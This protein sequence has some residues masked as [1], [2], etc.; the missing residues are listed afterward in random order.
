MEYLL[1]GV[2]AAGLVGAGALIWF[3]VKRWGKNEDRAEAKDSERDRLA[4]RVAELTRI[5]ADYAE[6]VDH[7]RAALRTATA[8]RAALEQA[9]ENLKEKYV[10]LVADLANADPAALADAVREQLRLLE[11]MRSGRAPTAPAAPGGDGEGAVH[12]AVAGGDP[13]R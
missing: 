12:A 13:E 11:A 7:T 8:E 4:T 3:I 6:E 2:L 9:L 1:G 5:N 10:S